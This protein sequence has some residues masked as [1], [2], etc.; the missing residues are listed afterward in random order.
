MLLTQG[1]RGGASAQPGAVTRPSFQAQ[2]AARSLRHLDTRP[3]QIGR[4][5]QPCSIRCSARFRC[6][7]LRRA[8]G[9]AARAP[10]R[11]S[12]GSARR[13]GGPQSR[14]PRPLPLHRRARG[15]E[16]GA[17]PGVSIDEGTAGQRFGQVELCPNRP[18]QGVDFDDHACA[19]LWFGRASQLPWKSV[20]RRGEED[21]GRMLR[22]S[23]FAPLVMQ[24]QPL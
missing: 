17:L 23:A 18:A 13:S 19:R 1:V 6:C 11:P 20:R 15:V 2:G 24:A 21:R 8:R 10:S 9:S 22:I 16:R 12:S 14:R 4:G 5:L 3:G 7:V